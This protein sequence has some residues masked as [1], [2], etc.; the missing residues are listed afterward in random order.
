[1]NKPVRASTKPASGGVEAPKQTS[2]RRT[3]APTQQQ[4]PQ[5][6]QRP[7]P[8]EAAP[9][10][11]L[12]KGPKE[13][14]PDECWEC[15][16]RLHGKVVTAYEHNYHMDCFKCSVCKT[17]L[18]GV[19]FYQEGDEVVCK[20]H[21][22]GAGGGICKKCNQTIENEY[23]EAED[24][25]YHSSCFVCAYG[26]CGLDAGWARGADGEV[27]CYLHLNLLNNS[28]CCECNKMVTRD[29]VVFCGRKYHG[30]CFVCAFCQNPLSGNNVLIIDL[31]T[32]RASGRIGG[33]YYEFKKQA[34]CFECHNNLHYQKRQ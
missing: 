10:K 32:N 15:G 14:A 18:V 34:F 4:Q 11:E 25:R 29:L 1:M 26:G 30:K 24:D 13:R 17:T 23:V 16:E 3:Q 5:Q 8:A 21:L 2:P 22:G 19:A 20:N 12:S 7:P 27:Y 31:C 28:N 33:R 9:A 6:Q